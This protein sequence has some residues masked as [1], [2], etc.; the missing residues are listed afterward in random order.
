MIINHNQHDHVTPSDFV[1]WLYWLWEIITDFP[2][3]LLHVR[4]HVG[5]G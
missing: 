1:T 4:G 2:Q 3:N 5:Y